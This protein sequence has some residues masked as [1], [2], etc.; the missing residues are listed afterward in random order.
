[1][2]TA[3]ANSA[4]ISIDSLCDLLDFL[5]EPLRAEHDRKISENRRCAESFSAL[6]YFDNNETKQTEIIASLLNP[7]GQH[8]QG[9]LF[10]R[11]F[12]T[13]VW[14]STKASEWS[15]Q[16]LQRAKVYPNHSI[17]C[18][19]GADKRHRF[20][21]LWIQVGKDI[22]LAIES[23]AKGAAD[24]PGQIN[25][26]LSYMKGR[27]SS[28]GKYKLLYLSPDGDEPCSDSISRPEWN[29]ACHDGLAEV[30]AHASFGRHWLT[31]CKEEC[32]AGR[33]RFFIEDLIAFVDP[34]DRRT[35]AMTAEM[36]PTVRELLLDLHSADPLLEA[37]RDTLLAIWE[38]SDQINMEI[39]RVLQRNLCERL[40]EKQIRYTFGD[41]D[42]LLSKTEWGGFI[43]GPTLEFTVGSDRLLA[44]AEIQRCP[45]GCHG[46]SH[47]HFIL[48][49]HIDGLEG[50]V[51]ELKPWRELAS[52]RL[53]PGTRDINWVWLEIPSGFE[54]LRSKDTAT[55]LLDPQSAD[56]IINRMQ[57]VLKTFVA[58]ARGLE[59]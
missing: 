7:K 56:D 59:Q 36:D 20:I 42:G 23:K 33:V 6:A 30:Q 55:K 18:G 28:S 3:L 39:V 8:G 49:I 5:G 9:T 10:L 34:N 53:G 19:D 57:D 22:C 11:H 26:Y 46:T 43:K 35:I 4:G 24:Q 32:E 17:D 44:Y 40:T 15:E 2:E 37:R 12:L 47:P 50:N 27:C 48:G 51:R 52:S 14:P 41:N 58:T 38:L 25:A 29:R 16:S 31:T 1:M 45:P 13:K 21:D 54:D